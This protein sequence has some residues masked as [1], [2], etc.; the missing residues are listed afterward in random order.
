MS[1][2]APRRSNE[3]W[4]QIILEARSCGGSDFEYCRSHGIPHS[5]FY[6]ALS[7]LRQQACELPAKPVTNE[8]RQEIVPVNISELPLGEVEPVHTL[9]ALPETATSSTAF[10]ATMRIAIG[11]STLELTNHVDPAVVGSILQML[12]SQC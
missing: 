7:R 8:Q 10:A 6:R 11:G 2:R 4:R 12:S 3:E 9:S 1:K 5:T